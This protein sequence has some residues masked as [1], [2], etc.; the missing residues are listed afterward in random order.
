MLLRIITTAHIRLGDDGCWWG[1]FPTS[2]PYATLVM[3]HELSP[4]ELQS[5]SG[6]YYL[7]NLGKINPLVAV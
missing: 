6:G 3:A 1:S 5:I 7:D 4:Q 2:P